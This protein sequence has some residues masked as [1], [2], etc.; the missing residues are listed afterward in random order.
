MQTADSFKAPRISVC[1]LTRMR[2]AGLARALEGVAKQRVPSCDFAQIRVIVVDNDPG[3]SGQAVCDRLRSTYPWLLDFA[4]EPIVGIPHAR[5][6][7]LEMAL[8]TDDL[9]AF[10]DDDE[11]PSERWLAELLRVRREYSADVVFGPVEPYFPEP[12]P[13]WIERG[14]FFDREVY[15]TGTVRSIGWTNNVLIS[16]SILRRSGIRFDEAYRFSGG[17]DNVFFRRVYQE[18]YRMV[19]ADEA[20]A[21]EW[22][23]R[24]R[25][26]LKWLA[27][28]HFRNGVLEGRRGSRVRRLQATGI[29]VARIGFGAG[30]AVVFLPFG[31]HLSAK[32]I[33]WASYGLGLV[34]GAAGWHFDEYRA[35]R[36]V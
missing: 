10:L 5:N 25:A 8:A 28:R 16:T 14:G 22:I 9:I 32:A 26:T 17:S 7:A 1:I 21:A 35:A 23:P 24:S 33:R 6:R 20:L 19:W 15:P 30:C 18:G 31:R 29:G 34:Y 3:R 13:R 11:V 12:V 27:M 4:L 36:G 2:E